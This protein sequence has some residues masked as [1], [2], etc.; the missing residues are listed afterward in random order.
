MV[1]IKLQMI[2]PT[3]FFLYL[4][5][6]GTKF[7]CKIVPK[8][9]TPCTYCSVIP[10]RNGISLPQVCINSVNNAYIYCENF[11]KFGPVTPEKI[12][13]ICELFVRHGKK[14]AYLVKYLRID[15]TN[16]YDLFTI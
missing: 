6:R 16:F 9:P 2:N 10:K 12:G 8:L 11:V 15:W 4:K 1:G 13:L 7:C 3:F 5:G 14:L